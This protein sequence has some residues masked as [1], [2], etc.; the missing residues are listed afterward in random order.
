MRIPI[1][2]N[3]SNYDIEVEVYE[4]SK[5]SRDSMGVPEEPDLEAGY[6]EGYIYH[7]C[8]DDRAEEIEDLAYNNKSVEH[9]I[10]CQIEDWLK[11]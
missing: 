9:D 7:T 11:V 4:G 10:Q 3:D 6:E 2:I 1:E 8:S 5:G